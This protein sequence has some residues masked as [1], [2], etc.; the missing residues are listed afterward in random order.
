ME[1][2]VEIKNVYGNER[3]Y[4]LNETAVY[5]SQLAKTQTLS[6]SDICKIKSLG[7]TIKVQQ[8]TL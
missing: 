8:K 6:K 7:F 5:F 2:L 1:L 4:P 3:I